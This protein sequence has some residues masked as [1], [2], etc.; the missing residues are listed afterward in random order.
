MLQVVLQPRLQPQ[1]S[2]DSS[3]IPQ[4]RHK[5]AAWSSDED[6]TE[7]VLWIAHAFLPLRLQNPFAVAAWQG[8]GTPAALLQVDSVPLTSASQLELHRR[9]LALDADGGPLR[10]VVRPEFGVCRRYVTT[11]S[12]FG[13]FE[14]HAIP[15]RRTSKYM[16]IVIK[17][18]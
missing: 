17:H 8:D 12:N 2:V 7:L 13:Q 5:A 1:Y 15:A 6:Q 3:T 16:F 10:Q 14:F 11:R 9:R 4:I 18:R